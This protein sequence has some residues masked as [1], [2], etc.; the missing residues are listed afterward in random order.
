MEL[1]RVNGTERWTPYP[2]EFDRNPIDIFYSSSHEDH[3]ERDVRERCPF[4]DNLRDFKIKATEFDG[5][6][7]LENYID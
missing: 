2:W 7:K 1:E 5:N 4:R 3:K 6:L